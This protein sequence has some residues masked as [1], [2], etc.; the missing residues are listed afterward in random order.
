VQRLRL[1]LLLR[2]VLLVVVL[3]VVEVPWCGSAWGGQEAQCTLSQ[4]SQRI[5]QHHQ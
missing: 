1:L 4:P 5:L 3:V 2:V